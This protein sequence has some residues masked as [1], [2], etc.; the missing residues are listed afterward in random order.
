MN[1]K[2]ALEFFKKAK[3]VFADNLEEL[4]RLDSLLGDGDHGVSMLKGFTS[5]EQ[6][7]EGKTFAS[8]SDLFM[9]AGRVL[10]S[11]IGGT[12]GPLFG[13]MFMSGA[14]AFR[15]KDDVGT[16]EFAAMF[17]NAADGVMKLGRCKAG[18]KTM[19][20]ALVPA[21]ESLK[22]SEAAGEELKLALTKAYE[23]AKAGAEATK[24]MLS[25]KGRGRYQG[26]KS[27]GC[28]D[29]GATSV[30]LILYALVSCNGKNI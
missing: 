30:S 10:M 4:S 3:N 24:G 9:N 7:L 18:E 2:Q 15:G 20:D 28:Q 1:N 19:V 6:S 21:G 12:C 22:A 23:A 5:I 17:T 11:E 25:T 26:E 8:I 14:T 16:P 27:L 13:T 29:P